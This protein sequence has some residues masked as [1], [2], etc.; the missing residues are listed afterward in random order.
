LSPLRL[1]VTIVNSD[2]CDYSNFDALQVAFNRGTM[3]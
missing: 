2:R 3:E 1:V